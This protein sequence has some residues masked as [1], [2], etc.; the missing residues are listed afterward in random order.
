MHFIRHE[1]F[2]CVHRHYITG[3]YAELFKV[4][5]V[6]EIHGYFIVVSMCLTL[7]LISAPNAVCG[8]KMQRALAVHPVVS[9]HVSLPYISV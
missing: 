3:Q 9:G 4:C 6:T 2:I 5:F 7:M 1:L 8:R